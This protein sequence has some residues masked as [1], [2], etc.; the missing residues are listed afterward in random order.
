MGVIVWQRNISIVEFSWPCP[1]CSMC[2]Y[3]FL[4]IMVM[5]WFWF[6]YHNMVSDF[7]RWCESYGTADWLG[8]LHA[9]C[10]W[11]IQKGFKLF[12]SLQYDLSLS[13]F[14]IE[15]ISCCRNAMLS[16][17]C[18]FCIQLLL[19]AIYIYWQGSFQHNGKILFMYCLRT[20]RYKFISTL[21]FGHSIQK[22]Y[23]VTVH[24]LHFLKTNLLYCHH[25]FKSL[26]L[27][28]T[29]LPEISVAL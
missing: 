3:C 19:H 21:C 12:G 11:W 15:I 23:S 13:C 4:K 17:I 27:N 20:P 9:N 28:F 2:V 7:A 26:F 25:H 5:L 24:L 29:F 8:F 10:S 22:Y 6:L 18:L 16:V 1:L 14:Y